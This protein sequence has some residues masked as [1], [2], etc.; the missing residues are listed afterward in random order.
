MTKEDSILLS[1]I[2]DKRNQCEEQYCVSHTAFLDIHQLALAENEFKYTK[3]I[4]YG[5]YDDAER[6]LMFFLPDYAEEIDDNP[7]EIL[8]V[9]CPKGSKVLS[10]R[11][12][13]GSILALGIDRSVIGDIIVK[14]NGAD[15]II[16]KSME[17]FLISNYDQVGRTHIKTEIV[18]I[19]ELDLGSVNTVTKRDTVASTRLDNIVSSAFNMSRAKAQEAINSGLVFVNNI[20]CD[21]VDKEIDESDKIVLRGKGKAILK[22]IGGKTRK[23]RIGIELELYV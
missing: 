16:L 15:I 6:R 11:D 19:D 18:P 4:L 3:H 8:R 21:K 9:T 12:Y 1:Q 2:E 23:D 5:G 14:E 17:D 13:L 20:Q 10:H 22:S 7:L